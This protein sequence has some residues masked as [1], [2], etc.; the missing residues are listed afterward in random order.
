M[1]EV[2]YSKDLRVNRHKFDGVD[3]VVLY[4]FRLCF[5]L[6]HWG[7]EQFS[8]EFN[9]SNYFGQ[10]QR[11]QPLSNQNSK[12]HKARENLRKQVAIGFGFT[13]D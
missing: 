11:T 6:N 12:L 13:Y 4:P 2:I 10:L 5:L 8:I 9:Q 7:L 3:P 1:R